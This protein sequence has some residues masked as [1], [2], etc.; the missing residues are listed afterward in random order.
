MFLHHILQQNQESLLYSFF[1]A[2]INTPSKD[3]VSSFLED[4]ED[5]KVYLEIENINKMTKLTF[6]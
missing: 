6:K 2:Q 4:M 1:N 3:R 5:L